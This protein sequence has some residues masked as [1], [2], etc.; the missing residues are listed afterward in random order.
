LHKESD[1]VIEP[2]FLAIVNL[3]VNDAN[4]LRFE[5]AGT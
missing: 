1:S 5:M 4:N 2:A 3:A